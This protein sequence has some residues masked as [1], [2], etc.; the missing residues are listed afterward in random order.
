LQLVFKSTLCILSITHLH[1]ACNLEIYIAHNFSCQPL[2]S[3]LGRIPLHFN[4]L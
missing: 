1:I 4:K 3:W 2:G